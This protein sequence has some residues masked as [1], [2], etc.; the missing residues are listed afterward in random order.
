MAK[1][2]TS[3]TFSEELKTSISMTGFLKHS[4][5][6]KIDMWSGAE[7]L[8]LCEEEVPKLVAKIR[9]VVIAPEGDGAVI[10]RIESAKSLAE[11]WSN[12]EYEAAYKGYEDARREGGW[13][14]V[15]EFENDK[16][17]EV[18]SLVRIRPQSEI[19]GFLSMEKAIDELAKAYCVD[20]DQ[21]EVI[22][23]SK[24]RAS[25]QNPKT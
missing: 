2:I 23:K 17:F 24:P 22:I 10:V 20:S 18:G 7:Y 4:G 9:E 6:I 8:I 12:N 25:V 11:A 15:F 3:N 5:S 1:T 21:I 14:F 16:F 19:Y 13:P